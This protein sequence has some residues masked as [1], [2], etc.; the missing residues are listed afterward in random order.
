MKTMIKT[1]LIL[2]IML[3]SLK[4]YPQAGWKI[5]GPENE[6]IV[7]GNSYYLQVLKNGWHL[8][9]GERD[10][11]I[12]LKWGKTDSQNIKFEKE[13]GG[14]IKADDKIAIYVEKGGYL[15]YESRK[16]GINLVWSKTPEYQFEL[17][18]VENKVGEAINTNVPIGIYNHIEKDFLINCKRKGMPVVD[19]AWYIDCADGERW[20]GGTN[21]Y[22]QI[23]KFAYEHKELLLLL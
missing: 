18:N 2:A 15:K 11:G 8:K 19:L 23:A 5:I 4:T 1:T 14:E 16:W 17:R 10:Y 21:K 12:N 20:P 7:S 3:T 9:Y 6:K 22:K 13:G